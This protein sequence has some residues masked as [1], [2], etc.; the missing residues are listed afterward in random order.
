M[1]ILNPLNPPA[2]VRQ[3]EETEQ[4]IIEAARRALARESDAKWEIGRLAH[5]WTQRH[6]KGRTD[7]DFAELVGG[8][9][10]SQVTQRRLVY[11]AVGDVCYSSNKL[12]WTHYRE[13]ASW[14][15][16]E[17]WLGEAEK[18]D[19]SVSRM[20]RER[21]EAYAPVDDSDVD[22]EPASDPKP[23]KPKRKAATS[24]TKT[25]AADH[26]DE[27]P[28]T[29]T[30]EPTSTLPAPPSSA[31]S[32]PATINPDD[33]TDPEEGDSDTELCRKACNQLIKHV[34]PRI[35]ENALVIDRF[36]RANHLGSIDTQR[37]NDL[38]AEIFK[39]FDQ[40][41]QTLSK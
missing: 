29:E 9:T 10:R 24:K 5:E 33:Q 37:L 12:S 32:A 13:A 36:M 19:W 18:N 26:E 27:E 25:V 34:I 22:D 38:Q 35:G 2:I 8:L 7:A 23:A 3:T 11:A 6:S 30:V 15:D 41:R 20:I 21:K 39:L 4:Q 16:S 14:D 40:A 1:S 31:H 17:E 28:A